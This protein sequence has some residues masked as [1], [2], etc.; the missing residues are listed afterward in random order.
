M[1]IHR[2]VSVASATINR[3]SYKNTN[4]IY[5]QLHKRSTFHNFG[6]VIQ[7]DFMK[8]DKNSVT[9]YAVRIAK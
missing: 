5:K 3:V 4:N 2:H 1:T 7:K 6:F 8:R 9:L